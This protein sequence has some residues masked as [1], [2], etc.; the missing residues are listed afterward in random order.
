MSVELDETQPESR[1]SERWPS[2]I[3]KYEIERELGA[4]GN[5]IVLL[6][7]DPAL[8]QGRDQDPPPRR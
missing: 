6:A 1:D 2:H 8:D 7:R 4:G 3:G 5:G